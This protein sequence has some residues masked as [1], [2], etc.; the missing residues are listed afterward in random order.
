MFKAQIEIGE[1]NCKATDII[2][3]LA[4]DVYFEYQKFCLSPE[5]NSKLLILFN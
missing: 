1:L 5:L 2:P 3:P 4:E